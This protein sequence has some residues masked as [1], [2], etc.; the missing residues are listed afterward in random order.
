[1]VA[2]NQA[3]DIK[4]KIGIIGPTRVGKTSM[5]TAMLEQGQT[6]LAGTNVSLQAIGN[7]KTRINRY[8]NQLN[9][10]LMA[11]EFTP[12]EIIGT[13]DAFT[14][15]LSMSVGNS[16]LTWAM[17]DYPGTWMNEESR[18][19]DK[20]KEW[21]NCQTWINDSI[22]L[23]VPI[24]AAVVMESSINIKK[25]IQAAHNTLQ[26]SQA[27]AVAREWAKGRIHK[28]EPG[29]LILVP[30]KC[31]TYFSDNNG[32][33]KDRSEKLFDRIKQFYQDLLDAVDQEIKAAPNPPKILIQY[34]PID[35]IG[36]VAIKSAEWLAE[37]NGL[38]FEADYLVHPPHKRCQKGADG[39]L[40]A[41]CRQIANT[42]K[43]KER[44]LFSRFWRWLTKED[45][46]LNNALETLQ[47]KPLGN[48]V[49]HL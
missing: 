26:I 5:I 3:T 11:D 8:L 39:L 27:V 7:T 35:T 47:T 4:Y 16:K 28:G 32:G 44:G 29:S 40:I 21:N 25:E 43:N 46:D 20:E 22:V 49:K 10:S 38:R 17:L 37:D 19:S 23:L 13:R 18:P 6:L 14:I 24:D 31:E 36:C 1:M 9:G 48:R 33:N 2:N 45:R 41:I 15:E 42:D 30:V 34:H 12:G